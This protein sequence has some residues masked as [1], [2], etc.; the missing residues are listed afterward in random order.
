M[1]R[2]SSPTI[3]AC[4]AISR[5]AWARSSSFVSAGN[6][7]SAVSCSLIESGDGSLS[8]G[9]RDRASGL[10]D[11]SSRELRAMA[12]VITEPCIGVKDASCLDVCPVDCI[13]STDADTMYFIHPDEC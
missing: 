6:G 10:R 11:L 7:N 12:Y 3:C 4:L 8:F 9:W 1:M 5:L 2:G 13:Y